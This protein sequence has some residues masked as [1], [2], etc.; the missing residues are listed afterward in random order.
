M[1]GD[2]LFN[3]GDL[4]GTLAN[5][6]ARLSE[7]VHKTPADHVLQ[8]DE[9]AWAD[10]LA[11][12]YRVE[13]PV[14][15]RDDMWQEE[16]K[17][18]RIDVSGYPG[19]AVMPGS[20][21]VLYP[22]YRVDIHLPFN[23]DHG[24]F[25]LRASQFSLNPPRAIVREDELVDYIEYPHDS[26]RDINAHAQEL[27]SKVEQ[28]LTWSRNDIEQHNRT[29]KQTPVQAIRG[30]R[31]QVERHQQH[32]AATGLPVG[33]P[34][35]RQKTY[36]ADALVRLPAPDLPRRD[37]EPVQLEPVLADRVFE[38]ILG[39]IRS[40][41]AMMEA[42]PRTYARMGEEDRR[43][44]LIAALNTH[45]RGQTTAETFHFTGRTDILVRHE[46]KNLFIGEC[47]VWAGPQGFGET[48]DQLLRYTAW[49]DTKLAIVAFVRQR[50]LTAIID[51]AREALEEHARFVAWSD[52]AT[53]AELRATVSWPGDERRHADLNVFFIHT[54]EE[55]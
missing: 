53:E 19:R 4:R 21:P 13:A 26:P 42:S 40:T 24:V 17:E 11:E 6:Q 9:E 39:V 23:G 50:N 48:I 25:K 30:R 12:R 16:P 14:L 34:G 52:A 3:D 55:A 7:D 32:I 37:E 15:R 44:V 38:H 54:P 51:K 2:L 1:A 18:I 45:Y 31:E 43:Q 41:G 5:I 28:H 29:L 46:N 22:G 8:A 49:R 20:G 27:A 36:I 10:A 33:R 47:K 35:Q